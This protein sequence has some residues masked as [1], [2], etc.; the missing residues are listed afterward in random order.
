MPTPIQSIPITLSA[1]PAPVGIT[2]AN[3]NQLVANIAQ[4]LT[5]NIQANVSFF[6]IFAGPPAYY[7]GDVI[8]VTNLGNFMVWNTGSGSYQ[9][10]NQFSIGAV[11]QQAVVYSAPS[12]DDLVNGWVYLNGRQISAIT[13]LSGDQVA[14][15]N[16]LFVSGFLANIQ[17][18]PVFPV[19]QQAAVGT[20]TTGPGFLNGETIT[21]AVSGATGKVY[22]NQG[23]GITNLVFIDGTG[24]PNATGL[25]TGGTSASTFTPDGVT[26]VIPYYG[27]ELVISRVYCGTNIPSS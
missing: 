3:F 23:V 8:F 1:T 22:K 17:P 25:W 18:L 26:G 27:P 6:Q 10:M 15:L 24:T 5:G 21:Q 9:A 11:V 4:Y 14:N 20:F 7:A 19:G 16:A 12:Y 2:A 13:G